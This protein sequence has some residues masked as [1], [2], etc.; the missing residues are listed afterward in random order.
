MTGNDNLRG[1]LYMSLAMAAFT[2]N[3]SCMKAVTAEFPLAQAIALRGGIAVIAL[4]LLGWRRG[5]LSFRFPPGD[6]R[7]LAL[8]SLAEV[9]ATL[10]F[11]AALRHMPLANLSAIMQALPL[12]VTLAAAVALRAP[13]GWRRMAAIGV[14]FTG[15][16]MIVRPGTAGFDVWSLVGLAS[17]GFVVVRDLATRRLSASVPSISV[18]FLAGVSVTVAAGC[19]LPFGGWAPVRPAIAALI[20]GAAVFLILGYL[21]IVM[22]MRVGEVAVVAPFRYTALIFAIT[23]GWAAFGELPDAMTL[24]G[25]GIIIAT[26]V[27]TFHRERRLGQIVAAPV[28]PPLRLR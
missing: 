25:A 10:T 11:L 24:I 22:A 13:V 19:L 27:Y 15:V 26:G 4:A 21:L 9:A 18:A 16:L 12:A 3:D 7:L 1:A 14:G 2:I 5:Q 17:V 28:T 20:G 23:L 6:G 8:R